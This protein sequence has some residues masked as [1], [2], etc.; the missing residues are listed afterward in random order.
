MI[1]G[2]SSIEALLA[3]RIDK[4]SP[5]PVYAQIVDSI[6]ALLRELC[7]APGAPFPPERVM[8]ERIGVSKMT[9][10]HAYGLLERDGLI[11][12]HRGRGTFVAQPHMEKNLPEMRSFSEEMAARGKTA[13]SRVL[14]L[15]VKQPGSRTQ[16]FLAL[17]EGQKVYEI[18]RLRLADNV[19]IAIETVE[20]PEHLLPRLQE[21]D[22]QGASLYRILE[23]SYGIRLVRCREEISAAMPDASQKKLLQLD[24]AVALLVIKRMSY[25][26]ND[27]PVELAVTVY[28]GDMY[29]AAIDAVRTR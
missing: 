16:Q 13:S 18:Q 7:L 22:L 27:Q 25:A 10:R 23:E 29:T 28:C 3:L 21:F 26:A 24:R 2:I 17:A 6:R 8:C 4:K 15:R 9:L 5:I 12:S 1:T 11:E 14:R 20:L 19:P